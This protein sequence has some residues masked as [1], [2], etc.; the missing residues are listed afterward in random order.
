MTEHQGT[1]R[2]HGAP[3]AAGRPVSRARVVDALWLAAIGLVAFATRV[4]PT[5][6][7]LFRPSHL[8]LL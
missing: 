1:A 6:S 4:Y 7:L 3:E 8:D 2:R 5:W